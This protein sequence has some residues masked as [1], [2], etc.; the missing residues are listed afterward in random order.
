M[1]GDRGSKEFFQIVKPQSSQAFITELLKPNGDAATEQKDME[2]VCFNFYSNL[3][4][5]RTDSESTR[6]S[7]HE[8]LSGATRKLTE[9]MREIL[10]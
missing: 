8:V 6:N 7:A 5:R 10:I 9:K 4:A 2:D 3:Y 1:N